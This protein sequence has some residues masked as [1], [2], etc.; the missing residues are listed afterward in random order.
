MLM[1]LAM[2]RTAL[3]SSAFLAMTVACGGTDDPVPAGAP[4]PHGA[5]APSGNASTSEN[6]PA[7]SHGT[8]DPG[9]APGEPSSPDAPLQGPVGQWA[10]KDVPG[11]VCGFGQQTGLAF[12][13]GSSP[14]VLVYLEGGG[15][16]FNEA[17]CNLD[18]VTQP[19]KQVTGPFG[20]SV[21]IPPGSNWGIAQSF[22]T[23]WTGE[24]FKDVKNGGALPMGGGL[25]EAGRFEVGIFDRQAA[26]NPFKDWSFIYVP[27]CTGDFHTGTTTQWFPA[28]GQTAHFAGR[29]NLE[30]D[31]AQVAASFPN[32][33]HVVL[34]GTSAGGFG[35]LFNFPLAE[36]VFSKARVDLVTD[37]APIFD[38]SV[39]PFPVPLFMGFSTW[40]TNAIIPEDCPECKDNYVNLYGYYGRK[41]PNS[42]FALTS[43]DQD[44]AIATVGYLMDPYPVNPPGAVSSFYWQISAFAQTQLAPLSN[45]RYFLPDI[46]GHG[47]LHEMNLVASNY[48]CTQRIP[49]I[50]WCTAFAVEPNPISLGG[51]LTQMVEDDPAWASKNMVLH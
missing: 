20:I 24:T 13:M 46:A 48:I 30:L 33:P 32:T 50:G 2:K 40:N 12:N 45:W 44:T 17:T 18:W 8:V 7:A 31:L 22:E 9:G 29:T 26:N 27:Y 36:K 15:M 25:I 21:P 1:L 43:L 16:C 11:A 10:W 51:F 6:P 34:S 41:Y 49:I 42:R 3:L 28:A 47:M 23:G 14:N 5:S 37:S 39:D 4:S 35:A 38:I 19:L